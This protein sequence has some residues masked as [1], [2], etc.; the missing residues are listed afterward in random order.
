VLAGGE[1]G[2]LGLAFHPDYQENGYFYVNYTRVKPN[3]QETVIAR[4]QVTE[5]A[6]A[7]DPDSEL[8]LLVVDQPRTNHNGG[9]LHF[10]P[11][12]MLYIGLGDG[13][14]AGDPDNY[15]QNGQQLLG[16]MLRL[17]VD[18]VAPGKNY[19]IPGDN[20]F[21][22]QPVRDEIWALGLRNP[23]RFSFD[24][25]TGDLYIGDVGQGMWEEVDFQPAGSEGGENYGWR[26]KEGTHC[27]NPPEA[28]D[29]G[30]LT[31]PVFEYSHDEGC[32]ITGGTVYR[33]QEIP[34]LRGQY[35]FAD[36]CSGVVSALYRDGQG[37][38]Q[39]REVGAA[40][41][42]VTTFGESSDGEVYLALRSQGKL[43]RLER[44]GEQIYLPALRG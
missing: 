7:A 5:D 41:G 34:T 43:L 19:G 42:N 28:C 36:Y 30:G 33:G 13:G 21:I 17:D 35:L 14:S 39:H 11:D 1:M 25:L 8:I 24:R 38:W 29:P 6:N 2:L 9:A 31:D 22:G 10:A 20:P 37:V 26:L 44:E 12:G 15:A 18:N 3:G 32:S 4:Y 16:K 23:W 27:Y 40:G